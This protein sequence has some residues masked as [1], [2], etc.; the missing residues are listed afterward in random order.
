MRASALARK[1]ERPVPPFHARGFIC[2]LSSLL[3]FSRLPPARIFSLGRPANR[4]RN[5]DAPLGV[6]SEEQGVREERLRA[7]G[8]KA[9]E[10]ESDR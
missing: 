7:G 5:L 10:R 8:R 9:I 4:S 2:F 1:C 3:V 6:R